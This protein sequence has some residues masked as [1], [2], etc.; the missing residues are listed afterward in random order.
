MMLTRD[1]IKQGLVH[2]KIAQHGIVMRMLSASELRASLD[3]TLAGVD[4]SAG[5]WVFGYGSLTAI[6]RFTSAI[7]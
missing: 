3:A 2:K 7:A 4:L 6:R 5:V 1:S